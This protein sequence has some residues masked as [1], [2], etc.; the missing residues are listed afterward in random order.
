MKV[1]FLIY[2]L[3][4]F[5]VNAMAQ[6]ST[7]VNQ[8]TIDNKVSFTAT[9]PALT[10][11]PGAPLPFYSYLWDFG[12]GHFSTEAAPTHIYKNE[13][14]Y[15]ATLYAVNNY[16]DGKKPGSKTKPVQ[17][18]RVNSGFAYIPSNAEKSFFKANGIFESK[19]NCMAKPGDSMV[20]ISG[21][22]NMASAGKLFLLINEKSFGAKCFDTSGINLYNQAT[23]N[24]DK[25]AF[26][27]LANLQEINITSSGS[28]ASKIVQYKKLDEQGSKAIVQTLQSKYDNVFAFDIP[29]SEVRSGYIFTKLLVTAE[30][31]KDTSATIVIS[32][33]FVPDEGISQLH[34]LNIPIVTSHDPNKM[35][36]Q[37]GPLSYRALNKKKSLPYKIR[38]QNNGEGP[39]RKIALQITLPSALDAKTLK[40]TEVSPACP[41]CDSIKKTGCYEVLG[42]NDSDSLTIQFNVG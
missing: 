32:G 6:D 8:I 35:S 2:S 39:A 21:W 37:Q 20:I 5:W 28:P 23:F 34:Q 13:G 4:F 29:K 25:N 7:I 24:N 38:F 31:L 11:I 30:M 9:L 19:Y 12:D 42:V 1:S 27:S 22:N 36:L 16:D 15:N 40:V 26:A 3:L 17:V 18:N 41:P 14:N 10:Q 33:L